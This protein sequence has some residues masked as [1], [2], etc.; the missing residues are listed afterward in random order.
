MDGVLIDSEPLHEAALG[1]AFRRFSLVPPEGLIADSKGRT[2]LE[3]CRRLLALHPEA[4]VAAEAIVEAKKSCYRD[5]MPQLRLLPGA[6]RCLELLRGR[7]PLGLTT[8]A[9]AQ[10]QQAV[11]ERFGLQGAFGAVVTADDVAHSKPHPEPYAR[12][13]ARLGVAPERCL[14]VEDAV[15]GVRS[16]AGAGCTVIG[17]GGSFGEATLREAGAAFFAPDFEA[18]QAL[19]VEAL[20]LR[21]ANEINL[22]S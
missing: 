15:N 12:T 20:S 18:V 10:D 19:L 9:T 6:R 17:L 21:M 3:V 16:A 4:S 7:A 2:D 11:F 14:A 13:A 8:S 22:S 1:E 5:L